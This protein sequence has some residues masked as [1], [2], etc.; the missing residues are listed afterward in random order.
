MKVEA[1]GGKVLFSE[2]TTP[3]YEAGIDW[4]SHEPVNY[5]TWEDDPTKIVIHQPTEE[6]LNDFTATLQA[7]G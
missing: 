4:L 3:Q 2:L 6:Q 1:G 5:E 7:A